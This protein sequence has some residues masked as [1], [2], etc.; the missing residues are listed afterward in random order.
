MSPMRLC[1]AYQQPDYAAAKSHRKT[2]NVIIVDSWLEH[3]L[4]NNA[5]FLYTYPMVLPLALAYGILFKRFSGHDSKSRD[6][7]SGALRLYAD[8]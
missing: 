1:F 6:S 2:V 4:M 3:I 7:A 8:L 5:Y